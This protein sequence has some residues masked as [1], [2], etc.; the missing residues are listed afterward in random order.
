MDYYRVWILARRYIQVQIKKKSFWLVVLMPVLSLGVLPFL[1]VGVRQHIPASRVVILH[2]PELAQAANLLKSS[3]ELESS[4]SVR[5]TR[6]AVELQTTEAREKQQRV[7]EL[8][9]GIRRSELKGFVELYYLSAASSEESL[10]HCVVHIS[11]MDSSSELSQRVHSSY[12]MFGLME[13][14]PDVV[15]DPS[16][17]EHRFSIEPVHLSSSKEQ[18]GK[19]EGLKYGTLLAIIVCFMAARFSQSLVT[20]PLFTSLMKEKEGRIVET[21]LMSFSVQDLIVGRLI[22]ASV[23]G[24]G[25]CAIYLFPVMS[26][27]LYFEVIGVTYFLWLF[28]LISVELLFF[29]ACY[30]MLGSIAGSAENAAR[31]TLPLEM[32]WMLGH[33]AFF[34]VLN[35]PDSVL[36]QALCFVPIASTAAIPLRL[37][38]CEDNPLFWYI[39]SLAGS[40]LLTLAF[41]RLNFLFVDKETLIFNQEF[42]MWKV[43]KKAFGCLR[44]S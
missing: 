44:T 26:L 38:L 40:C 33:V 3:L 37:A 9:Q 42:S 39:V 20:R 34:A 36:S 6:F 10:P 25:V 8:S 31:L 43:L 22:G 1:F 17:E 11:A 32:I 35:A 18:S 15:G 27:C 14:A 4:Q 7:D 28:V 13:F 29:G 16:F 21:L 2:S 41:V 30:F 5:S 23:L 24:L 19:D 12:S